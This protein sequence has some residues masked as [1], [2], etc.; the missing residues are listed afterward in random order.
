MKIAVVG[1]GLSGLTA[2][3]VLAEAGHEVVIYE[4][5]KGYGGRMA[6]RY[7]GRDQEQKLDH[8]VSYFTASDSA[9]LHAV[10]EWEQKG[11][12]QKWG[13]QFSYFTGESLIPRTPLQ[14]SGI[15]TSTAGM[16]QIG[17]FIGRSSDV[18]FESKV[19]GITYFGKN[20]TRKR[21]WM[22]NFQSGQVVSADAVILATPAPQAYG[23]LGMSQD[24]TDTY[25]ILRQIDEIRYDPRF[26][27][28]IGFKGVNI[29]KWQGI[30]CENSLISFISNESLKRGDT[31]SFNVT[32]QSTV[33]FAKQHQDDLR[34][35]VADLLLK[36]L[37]RI[38]GSWVMS[39]DW[40]QIH[41]WRYSSCVNPLA[42]SFLD[43][44]DEDAPLAL[45]GD[46]FNEGTIQD[47]YLSGYELGQLWK[48]R[49]KNRVGDQAA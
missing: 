22:I 29:P 45:I 20:R 8:G 34:E 37:S 36:E 44:E 18:V 27:M 9:F 4:K 1:A 14:E 3:K 31:Q 28:I 26:S 35:K 38:L 40:K 33:E 10:K 21:P 2:G 32:V 6:T 16:N 12:V 5:S 15:Y 42:V 23:I 49:F 17:R 46:Y 13:G 47:A 43:R 30:E 41:F 24:E 19:G 25:K 39:Y 7:A 11:L 48:K